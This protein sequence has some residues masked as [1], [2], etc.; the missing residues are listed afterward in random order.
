MANDHFVFRCI[1]VSQP[2]GTFYVGAMDSTDLALISYADMRRI[3]EG[4]RDVEEFSGIQRPLDPK[5]V[6]ELQEYVETVD[7]AFPTSIILQ[8][9]SADVEYDPA[10][11]AM[12]IRR[13]ERIAKI[14]DG[15]HRIAGLRDYR[16]GP[17]FELNV[18]IFVDMDMEDQALLFATINLKQTRVGKS[19]AYDLYEFAR[20]RSPQKTCHNIAKLL[21]VRDDSPLH[22]RIKI[23]GT[24][25]K[26]R[27][28]TLTQAA[29]VDN[30][31]PLI[32]DNP[33]RD[34][35][36]LKR[37]NKL[38]EP[39]AR[40]KQRLVFRTLFEANRDAKI[41]KNLWNFFVAVKNRWPV[42]WVQV[43]PG[44]ILNRTTGLVALM[45]FL[46][47]VFHHLCPDRDSVLEESAYEDVLGRVALEDTDFTREQYLP[48]TTGQTQLFR[49]LMSGAGFS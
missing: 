31:I 27:Q 44:L 40:Y 1:E 11:S 22:H 29:F 30:L 33:M 24:A 48:G 16:P 45:R 20:A 41:A 3:R 46:G 18:T 7:A 21:N 36:A 34:R 35:D 12:Q 43:E 13:E 15:Q 47:E 49:D 23:L 25:T 28:E 32:S 2:I 26:G 6:R 19:L 4:P 39:A 37:G 9:D 8:I 42:A 38:P 17:T 5:R 10:K 14:I